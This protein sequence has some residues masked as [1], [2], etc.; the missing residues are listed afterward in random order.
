LVDATDD[1]NSPMLELNEL[2]NV[3]YPVVPVISICEE[4][5]TNGVV[6]ETM[7]PVTIKEPVIT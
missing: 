2:L 7:V 3:E 1:D 4:P 6:S 5:D